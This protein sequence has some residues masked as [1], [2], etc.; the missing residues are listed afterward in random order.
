MQTKGHRRNS[1]KSRESL[2]Q[3]HIRDTDDPLPNLIADG[4]SQKKRDTKF[5]SKIK[6]RETH[7]APEEEQKGEQTQ[8]IMTVGREEIY[9]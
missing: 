5:K 4:R 6:A 8:T 2:R 7:P 9:L 3:S 1:K